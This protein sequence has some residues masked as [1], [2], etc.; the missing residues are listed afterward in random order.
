[1]PQ[2]HFK[3]L[4]YEEM[5]SPEEEVNTEAIRDAKKLHLKGRGYSPI[6]G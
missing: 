3:A 6:R 5:K 2:F 4:G 1:M